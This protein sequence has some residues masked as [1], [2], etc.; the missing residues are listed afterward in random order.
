M[1]KIIFITYLFL[2]SMNVF[3]DVKQKTENLF[4]TPKSFTVNVYGG[5]FKIDEE[6]QLVNTHNKYALG[7]GL[8]GEINKFSNIG[9]DLELISVNR[10]YDTPL[11]PPL[12]GTIDKST[13][14]ETTAML[15]GGKLFVP[16]TG[17]LTA[18]VSAGLGYFLTKMRVSGTII[19]LL[20]SLY[21]E[22]NC[23]IV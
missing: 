4:F 12:F 23:C 14:V 13:R 9:F 15:L 2:F 7:F 6:P 21:V 22:D 16:K 11:G 5:N 1:N 3:S 20:A 17:P 19:G 18:Y 10:D 8:S